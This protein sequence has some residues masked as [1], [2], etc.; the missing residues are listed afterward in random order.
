MG[1]GK[2]PYVAKAQAAEE[3]AG[4]ARD[5]ASRDRALREAAHEWDRAAQKEL[6]G[7]KR[8]EYE[9]HAERVRKRVE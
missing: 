6:P 4:G 7:K 2:N 9:E 5:D 1:F 8:V 3:K